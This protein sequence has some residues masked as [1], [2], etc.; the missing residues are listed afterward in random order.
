MSGSGSTTRRWLA[1]RTTALLTLTAFT[2]ATLLAAYAGVHGSAD[3]LRTQTAPAILEVAAAK[4]ALREAHSA[5]RTTLDSDSASDLVGTGEDYRSQ[6][7][8]ANQSLARAA[9]AD[10]AGEPGLRQLQTIAGLI[11]AYTG[12]IEQAERSGDN[13][14]QREAY[15][16]YAWS[17]LDEIVGLLDREV[18]DPQSEELARQATPWWLVGSAWVVAVALCAGFAALSPGRRASLR[19]RLRRRSTPQLVAAALALAPLTVWLVAQVPRRWLLWSAWVVAVVLCAAL[20]ALLLSTQAALRERFRRRYSRPLLAAAGLLA[21]TLGLF[22]TF[23]A[24][25]VSDMSDARED[26]MAAVDCADGH[27]SACEEPE[28]ADA[29]TRV[30]NTLLETSPEVGS[31]LGEHYTQPVFTSWIWISAPAIASLIL[32]GM[33]PRLAEYRYQE[34]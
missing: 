23:T 28:N 17:V 1:R 15:L 22:V 29:A 16:H 30:T 4:T 5:A 11:V 13:L 21:L 2:V 19:E 14:A 26:L 24:W 33:L 18:Q 10:V 34:R 20:A 32:R 12:W 7:A 6:L 27:D 31:T 9:E 3:P 25:T 8:A